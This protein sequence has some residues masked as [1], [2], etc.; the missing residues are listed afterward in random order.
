M[1][2]FG[3]ALL[4]PAATTRPRSRR[5]EMGPA[6]W[7]ANVGRKLRLQ[8]ASLVAGPSPWG[9]SRWSDERACRRGR[10]EEMGNRSQRHEEAAVGYSHEREN[11]ARRSAD[12]MLRKICHDLVT[13][14]VAIRYLAQAIE[15]EPGVSAEIRA[16]AISIAAESTRI[17]E[18]CA[19]A[20]DRDLERRPDRSRRVDADH[21][22]ARD[23]SAEN[24]PTAQS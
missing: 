15:A 8:R 5:P 3:L 21:G 17:S 9:W 18:V 1:A 20:L 7:C 23:A 11:I 24:G 13:P 2:R 14:A 16:R 10:D 22:P 12:E 4:L 6:A 19:F